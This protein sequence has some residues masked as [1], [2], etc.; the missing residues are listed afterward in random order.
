MFFYLELAQGI[1]R[2]IWLRY[3]AGAALVYSG[4]VVIIDLRAGHSVDVTEL[5]LVRAVKGCLGER[6]VDT[7]NEV[8][9]RF[10]MYVGKKYSCTLL[11]VVVFCLICTD[12]FFAADSAIAK[13]DLITDNVLNLSSSTL[14]LLGIR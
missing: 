10:C 13:I 5:A 3:L 12:A 8:E 6:L 7:Y 11:A 9:G 1:R 2:L 14:A 4:Q